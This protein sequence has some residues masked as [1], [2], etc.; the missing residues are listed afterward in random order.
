MRRIA[1]EV[2]PHWELECIKSGLVSGEGLIYHVRDEGVDDKRLVA[3]EPEFASI[4]KIIERKDNTLSTAMRQSW[5]HG[6]LRTMSK[7]SAVT[8]TDAHISCISHIT[9][10]ELRK[11]L[12]DT[13]SFNG[14][15]NRFMFVCVQRSKLLPEG[16]GTVDLSGILPRMQKAVEFARN[17][18]EMRRDDDARAF[19]GGLMSILPVI[20]PVSWALS[21]HG[22]LPMSSACR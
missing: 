21:C 20:N 18:G 22:R 19:W 15:A 2:D 11:R 5:D 12:S 3:Y 6:R 17:V 16:G 13:E 10:E 1:R 14:F 4:L 8:A 9:K 7:N